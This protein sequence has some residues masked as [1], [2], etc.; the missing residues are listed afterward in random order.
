MLRRAVKCCSE[1]VMNKFI[2]RVGVVTVGVCLNYGFCAEDVDYLQPAEEPAR[3][4]GQLK[5]C[6]KT[7]SALMI[8]LA[9]LKSACDPIG[10]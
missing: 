5:I 10:S 3:K 8:E 6:S 1:F 2:E 7:F 9:K 4:G